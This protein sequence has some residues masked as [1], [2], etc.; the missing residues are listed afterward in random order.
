MHSFA[1]SWLWFHL[2]SPKFLY[3]KKSFNRHHFEYLATPALPLTRMKLSRQFPMI[4]SSTELIS[5][6]VARRLCFRANS[7]R[8]ASSR[9]VSFPHPIGPKCNRIRLAE[10]SFV[11]VD[12][13]GCCTS[14][15]SRLPMFIYNLSVLAAGRVKSLSVRVCEIFQ[16]S[17]DL[18]GIFMGIELYLKML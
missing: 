12:G 11:S 7:T 2:C 3:E 15:T 9:T 1:I 4:L 16:I 18:S 10:L 6:S 14:I 8:A 13:C 17:S 5:T